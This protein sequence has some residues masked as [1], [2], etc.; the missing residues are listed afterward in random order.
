[1]SYK[2]YFLQMERSIIT[3]QLNILHV[4]RRTTSTIYS[5][6]TKPLETKMTKGHTSLTQSLFVNQVYLP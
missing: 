3:S 6:S 2:P 5:L 1:M 4:C